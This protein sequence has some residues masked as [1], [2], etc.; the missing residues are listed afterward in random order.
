VQSA[1]KSDRE[2]L[3]LNGYAVETLRE[4]PALVEA[5][6]GK[7]RQTVLMQWARD[8]A[9]RF[10]PLL[11]DDTFGLTLHPFD[12]A[13]NKV[14]ALAGR[15]EVRDWIDVISCHQRIQNLGYLFWAA[16]GKDPGFSPS[17]LLAES[18][19]SSH[20]SAEEIAQLSF[21]G[22]PPDA[23]GLGRR[24]H[25]IQRE[26]EEIIRMLPAQYVGHCVIDQKGDLYKG[27][28]KVLADALKKQTVRFH[29]GTIKGAFPRIASW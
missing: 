14:L 13:T 17:S 3:E 6:V 23:A 5:R 11:T 16:C 26:A 15:L 22:D 27:S 21:A 19:R 1:W 10:F 2:L 20:Y 29:Q 24:W 4:M 18:K 9:F 28:P 12:L 25:E 8:S 7:E